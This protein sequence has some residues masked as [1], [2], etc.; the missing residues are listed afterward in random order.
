MTKKPA[1][2]EMNPDNVDAKQTCGII[3]PIAGNEIYEAGHWQRVKTM[4]NEAIE[5]A[6]FTPKMV[7]DADEVSVI[8]GSIVQNIYDNPIVVCDVSSRN[9]NVMFELGMRLAFD[10]PTIIVKDRD[11]D[12]SFDTQVIEHIAYGADLRYDDVR[13]FQA[14]LSAKIKATVA[15]KQEDA[16]Y[17]PFLRHFQHLVPQK[18]SS[19]EVTIDNFILSKLDDIQ[20]QIMEMRRSDQRTAASH[21]RS[22]IISE[23]ELVNKIF[24]LINGLSRNTGGKITKS[25]LKK[26]ALP[27]LNRDHPSFGLELLDTAFEK[28]WDEYHTRRAWAPDAE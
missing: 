5:D 1:T 26:N 21:M 11:T 13:D 19:K 15:K 22:V 24:A 25:A 4:L 10:K 6:G 8:H 2:D 3:M 17:S 27:M 20:M 12:Y 16:N 9:P 18:L 14:K 23:E 7:S 28:A